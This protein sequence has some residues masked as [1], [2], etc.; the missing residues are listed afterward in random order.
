MQ[1]SDLP[2]LD[3][4]PDLAL[5]LDEGGRPLYLNPSAKG[6]QQRLGQLIGGSGV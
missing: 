3:R 4:Y 5:L 1:T 6:L 2:L